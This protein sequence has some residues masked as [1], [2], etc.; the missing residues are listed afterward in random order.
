[1]WPKRIRRYLLP[2]SA[3]QDRS[4][5]RE[6]ERLSHL[7]LRVA[8]GIE[9]GAAAF[10]GVS[11][12][13]LSPNPEGT[14]LRIMQ[15]ASVIF[16][17]ILTMALARITSLR[18]LSRPLALAS[19]L[20][21]A[22]VL[23]WF[24]L[25]MTAHDRTADDF[26]PGQITLVL[27]VGVTAVPF[28]PADTLL[29]GF[30][31]EV[32]YLLLPRIASYLYNVPARADS[33]QILFIFML[34]AVATGLSA[35]VYE[36]RRA[37]HDWHART[38]SAAEDLRQAEARNLLAQNAASVG[39]L[40]AALSHELNSPI[41]A[42]VSGVDTLLLLASRQVSS[43]A[44][45]QQRLVILQ[46]EL[47]KSIKQSTD[48]LKE[49]VVRMQR[50]TNLDKAEVQS[51]NVNDILSDVA[52]LLEPQYKNRAE[53]AL[54]LE[55][56]PDLVCRPQQ[57]SAVFSNLLLNGVDATNGNGR[58]I[59]STKARERYIH[60]SICDNG[61][62]LHEADLKTIFDPGFRVA[63]GRIAAGNFSMFA[64]RQ[65][66]LEHGGEITIESKPG[67]GTCVRITFPPENTLRGLEKL[68]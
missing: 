8:G 60:I 10:M 27:L 43:P 56:V 40:A 29:L 22:A 3:E 39:R 34:T 18:R 50:F 31:I 61:R 12:L 1:M 59:V 5:R 20:S 30:S 46:N 6:V 23:I 41:G 13:L 47:R 65:I 63:S 51:A 17:G 48:R 38:L 28:R 42:L 35:V 4:F 62:G 14:G 44:A 68:S 57:L 49:I 53:L 9:A 2:G 58:V 64:N 45:E 55:P 15:A 19:G 24:S 37:T 54:Q 25:L 7:G 26:I 16:I 36:Q 11:R 67:A 21:V 33:V 32:L 52:A 66:V